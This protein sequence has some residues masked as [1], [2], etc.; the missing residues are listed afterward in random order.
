MK[1]LTLVDKINGPSVALAATKT[2]HS[3]R[4]RAQAD[5]TKIQREDSFEAD[6]S[7]DDGKGK[8]D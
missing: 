3:G 1:R 7:S 5:N 8:Y 6:S 4:T 2:Q